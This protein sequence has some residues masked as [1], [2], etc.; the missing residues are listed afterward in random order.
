MSEAKSNRRRSGSI[1]MRKVLFCA[2]ESLS[3][4]PIGVGKHQKASCVRVKG[5][6]YIFDKSL[7]VEW[8]RREDEEK[9]EDLLKYYC[10]MSKGED[11]NGFLGMMVY[12]K[13]VYIVMGY[14]KAWERVKD[15]L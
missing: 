11:S 13:K 2:L 9:T 14:R 3:F 15:N 4:I 6:F 5:Q 8:T 7:G 1:E 12:D 10:L